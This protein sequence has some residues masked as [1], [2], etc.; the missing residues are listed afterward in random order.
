MMLELPV[1]LGLC[2]YFY[3]LKSGDIRWVYYEGKGLWY[4]GRFIMIGEAAVNIVLK[5]VPVTVNFL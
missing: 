4:E 3:I 2:A 5:G 1:V